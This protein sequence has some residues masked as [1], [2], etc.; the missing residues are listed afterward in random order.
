MRR[1]TKIDKYEVCVF[2]NL[3]IQ[4]GFLDCSALKMTKCQALRKFWHLELFYWIYY[5]IWHYSKK[6]PCIFLSHPIDCWR[7]FVA[8]STRFGQ[9]FE[10]EVKSRYRCLV[11]ILKSMLNW[12]SEIEILSRFV[13]DFV[14]WTQPLVPLCLWQCFYI[15]NDS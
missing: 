12:G 11:D 8:L 14:I 4:G 13:K 5:V 6:T 15:Y 2:Q 7:Q 10:V 9:D 3:S 1:C